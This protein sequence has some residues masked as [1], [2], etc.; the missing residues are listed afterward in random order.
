MGKGDLAAIMGLKKFQNYHCSYGFMLN[1]VQVGGS[2]GQALRTCAV[3]LDKPKL[4]SEICYL[5]LTRASY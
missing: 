3:E 5:A 4:K 2:L 1:T